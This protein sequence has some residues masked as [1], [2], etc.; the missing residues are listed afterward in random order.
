MI[1][2]SAL[3]QTRYDKNQS[4][5]VLPLV[6]DTPNNADYDEEN[7][8]KI[9]DIVFSMK[10]DDNQIITSLVGF[11]KEQFPNYTNINVIYLNNEQRHLLNE[12]DFLSAKQEYAFL[13]IFDN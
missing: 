5:P 3:L 12:R 8:N 2:L 11:D 10:K 4:F 1:W 13:G 9:F 7:S 6:V